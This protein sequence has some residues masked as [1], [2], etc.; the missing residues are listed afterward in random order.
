[1]RAAS[2]ELR[3]PAQWRVAARVSDATMPLGDR[4]PA[5]E[6][7]AGTIRYSAGQMRGLALAGNWLGG[8]VEVESRRASAGGGLGLCGERRRRCSAVAQIVR[9]GRSRAT[10]ERPVR[11]DGLGA[12]E[13]RRR[14]V[15]GVVREQPQWRR[16]P[17]AGALRQGA[18]ARRAGGRELGI[19]RD[20]CTRISSSTAARS[21]SV[22]RCLPASPRRISKCRAS[23]VS[24]AGLQK[25]RR[26]RTCTIEELILRARRRCSP[27]PAPCC[28]ARPSWRHGRRGTLCAA[29]PGR[30]AGND[31][32]DAGGVAFSLDSAESSIHAVTSRV[33]AR[34]DGRC[35]AEFSAATAHLAAL[36]PMT[37]SRGVADPAMNATGS[38]DWPVD[39]QGD[40]ARSLAGS[41][42][43]R[44]AAPAATISS[45]RERYGRRM[46][47]SCS[48]ICRAPDLNPRSVFRGNGRIGLTGA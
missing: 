20:G 29:Q 41:S 30:A 18:R 9:P 24:C 33:N 31:Q 19:S 5:V 48:P 47:R 40:F 34:S 26:S 38:L 13:H 25:T 1:M 46:A 35:R 16:E 17:P 37:A 15:E 39:A 36:L 22:A 42:E 7:L 43:S 27:R 8:P 32:R 10:R 6:K 44:P 14:A 28:P 45:A 23:R 2:A 11:M 12:G 21:I 4:L 3:D